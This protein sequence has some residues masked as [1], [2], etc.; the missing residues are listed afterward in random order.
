MNKSQLKTFGEE[1]LISAS[2]KRIEK[3]DEKR[4]EMKRKNRGPLR[5]RNKRTKN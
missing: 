5:N 1:K 3:K 2:T 4:N